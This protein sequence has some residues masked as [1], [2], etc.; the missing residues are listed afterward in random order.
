MLHT[1]S[2]SADAACGSAVGGR[3]LRIG[4]LTPFTSIDFPGRLSAVIFVQGCPMRCCYC[5]NP[6]LQ[7]H[8]GSGSLHWREVRSWLATRTGLLDGVIFSGGEP[9]VDPMLEAAIADAKALGLAIGLHSAGTHPRRLQRLLQ[10]IDWIGLDVKA[11]LNDA[12]AYE[13]ISGMIGSATK[14]ATCVQHVLD[15]GVDYEIRTTAH[16]LWMD[17]A[18]LIR[19][20]EDLQA[21]GARRFVVQI[22]R[23][24]PNQIAPLSLDYPCAA[25]SARL[26]SM[27][28]SFELRSS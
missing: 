12:R 9:T 19:L 2:L 8:A 14:A 20:A 7:Q 6:H 22:A 4:G 24:T 28:D 18:M 5:H 23:A 3:E 21:R 15:S 25:A 1:S 17:D 26:H 10:L 11:P 16:P 13:R 27:F